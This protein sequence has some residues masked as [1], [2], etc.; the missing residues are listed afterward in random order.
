MDLYDHKRP[1]SVRWLLKQVLDRHAGLNRNVI[2]YTPHLC[3]I[4]IV[5]LGTFYSFNHIY[6]ENENLKAPRKRFRKL[7]MTRDFPGGPVVK[8]PPCNAGDMGSIPDGQLSPRTTSKRPLRHNK[9]PGTKMDGTK[10]LPNK[11]IINI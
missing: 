3:F 6:R 9:D 8:N 4:L 1:R 7:S 10:M 2:S 5:I 11:Q